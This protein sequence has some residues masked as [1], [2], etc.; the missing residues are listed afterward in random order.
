MA[1]GN[2]IIIK[3]SWPKVEY[4]L[5]KNKSVLFFKQIDSE[6]DKA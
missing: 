4:I 6:D 2:K 5:H 3:T 1:K